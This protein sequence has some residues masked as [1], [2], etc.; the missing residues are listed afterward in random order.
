MTSTV[1]YTPL[2]PR[3]QTKKHQTE[4]KHGS[5]KHATTPATA[6]EPREQK[7]APNLAFRLL[8]NRSNCSKNPRLHRLVASVEQTRKMYRAWGLL[9]HLRPTRVIKARITSKKFANLAHK[10][11]FNHL[12]HAHQSHRLQ[13]DPAISLPHFC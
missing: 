9:L 6:R 12:P 2:L 10:T 4:N 13:Q 7:H 5:S 1:I 8:T 3:Y 11:A